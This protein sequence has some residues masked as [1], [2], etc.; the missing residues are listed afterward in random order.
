MVNNNK[1]NMSNNYKIVNVYVGYSENSISKIDIIK[2]EFGIDDVIK[3]VFNKIKIKD[4]EGEWDD[5]LY[6]GIKKIDEENNIGVIGYGEEEII[7]V[8]G[9]KSKWYNKVDEFNLDSKEKEVDFSNGKYDEEDW[10]DWVEFV[11]GLVD[12][13]E[14]DKE[15]KELIV[16]SIV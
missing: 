10:D 1:N 11:E 13:I 16:D 15:Y 12:S 4:G 2:S 14:W 8:I 3:G 7:L 5:M 6:Y 9:D